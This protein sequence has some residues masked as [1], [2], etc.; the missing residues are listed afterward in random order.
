MEFKPFPKIENF[1]KVSMSITQKIH[2][3]N[4]QVFIQ[5]TS[6]NEPADYYDE[7]TGKNY[8]VKTGSRNR[9]IY[10]GHDNYGFSAFVNQHKAEFV[11]KLGVGQHFGEW[12]G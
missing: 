12:A 5:E 11:K 10:P 2:G 6:V 3:S 9:W 4:A 7:E 8:I 1:G